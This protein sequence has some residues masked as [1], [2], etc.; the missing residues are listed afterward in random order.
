MNTYT[1]RNQN[2]YLKP[3]AWQIAALLGAVIGSL[4]V[5]FTLLQWLLHLNLGIAGWYLL[6]GLLLGGVIALASAGMNRSAY[7]FD[8]SALTSLIS[9][10]LLCVGLFIFVGIGSPLLVGV[11]VLMLAVSTLLTLW[12]MLGKRLLGL[13]YP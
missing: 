1:T 8:W 7:T 3:A 4:V 5:F 6:A 9:S 10:V 2:A 11:V 12:V 13:P